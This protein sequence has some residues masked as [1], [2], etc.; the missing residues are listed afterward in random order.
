MAIPR[1]DWQQ[2]P[3]R[4]H[5]A[6]EALLGSVKAAKTVGD[7]QNS[8]IA[9]ILDVEAGRVF[10]KGLRT[11]TPAVVTQQREAAINPH[12]RAVAPELLWRIEI[13]GWDLLCFEHVD[14]RRADYTPGSA[15]LP[16]LVA[17]MRQLAEL[18]CPTLPPVYF[19]HAELRWAEVI[20][21]PEAREVL[22]G[23]T[24]LHTDYNPTNILV[25]GAGD[26][27]MIDWAW[28]TKGAAWVDPASLVPRLIAWGHSPT[29]AEE[30]ARECPAWVEA[31]P[32]AIDVFVAA[33]T[34]MWNEIAQDQPDED[35][36]QALAQAARAWKDHR[37]AAR[38]T[39]LV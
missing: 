29:T 34:T 24:I 36:K 11:D 7:G 30:V 13:A 14:G 4:V 21:D 3:T 9:T 19:R 27:Q 37:S 35:W 15:D 8:A 39:V 1:I 18:P 31:D 32:A 10:L 17:T 12:V 25:T 38:P 23:D 16:R 26:I 5:D 20:E 2:L 22:A 6:V 33:L 28:A